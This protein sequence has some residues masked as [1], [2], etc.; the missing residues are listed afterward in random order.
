MEIASLGSLVPDARFP[1]LL[2]S[3]PVPVPYFDGSELTFTFDGLSEE[4]ADAARK[5]V[6]AFLALGA[7]DRTAASPY[8]YENYRHVKEASGDAKIGFQIAS[9]EEVW[10]HV[11][12]SEIFVSQRGRRDDLL[13]VSITAE[14]D[15]EPE[16]GLQIVYRKGCEL[17]RVSYQDGHLTHTDAYDLPE[18]Q[19]QIV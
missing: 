11:H 13:Y 3:Q 14:C 5:A 17:S 12:P 2:V 18:E 16:H 10:R 15:W 8:V 4:Y 19:D 6:N 1:E 9:P 7:N